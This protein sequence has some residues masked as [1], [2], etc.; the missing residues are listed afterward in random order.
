MRKIKKSDRGLTFA[1][2]DESLIGLRFNYE[3]NLNKRTIRIVPCEDG[4]HTIS[5]KKSGNKYR[6]LVDIRSC[7]VK[8]LVSAA[9]YLEI[10]ETAD[11]IIVHVY[12]KVETPSV[13]LHDGLYLIDDVLCE[14]SA[15]IVIMKDKNYYSF[16]SRPETGILPPGLPTVAPYYIASLFSGA[17]LLDKPFHDDP[18]CKIVFA[19][20]F[21][22]NACKTYAVNISDLI[23]CMDIRDIREEEV[24]SCDLV[25]GGPCC[26]AYSNANRHNIHSEVSEAKRMLLDDYIRI[27]HAKKPEAFVIENA[28]QLLTFDNGI[29]LEKLRRDLPEYRLSVSKLK[30]TELGGYTKRVRA[31]IIGCLHEAI[32]LPEKV[33][34]VVKTV[35]DALNKVT[36]EWFNYDDYTTPSERTKLLM[37]YVPQGGNWQNIPP[38]VAYFPPTTHSQRY[39][40]LKWDE[41]SPTI[42]NFR[43][44]NITHPKENRIITVA[45]AAA[46]MGLEKDFKVYGS[47]LD[48]RQQ[49]VAN[50]V[51]GAM[52]AFIKKHVLDALDRLRADGRFVP[53]CLTMEPIG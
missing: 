16:I 40:R 11:R 17:G 33:V 32:T 24:P 36:P 49:Q 29:A 8:D 22:R 7:D 21:D 52:S 48:S 6:A 20:D 1:L 19:T 14:K 53:V 26:Q 27:V 46:L 31:I 37:S 44:P 42:T 13:Q 28:P 51:T 3:I 2:D 15:D 38:E 43:K 10:E 9:E 12:K 41:P 4:R 47:T 25:I 45:E 18:R 5:R 23:R 50:G 35:W 34:K 30:D 39:Y